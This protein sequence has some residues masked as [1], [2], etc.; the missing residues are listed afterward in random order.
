MSKI[1]S[2][3]VIKIKV[4]GDE[5]VSK[6]RALSKPLREKFGTDMT[7][8][9]VHTSDSVEAASRELSLHFPKDVRNKRR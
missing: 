6:L 4:E 7:Q 9:A 5:A 8:N 1:T 2:G 3:P